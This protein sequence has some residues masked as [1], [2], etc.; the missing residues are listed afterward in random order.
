MS[1][2]LL[3]ASGAQTAACA[4]QIVGGVVLAP[5]LSGT[6]QHFKARLQGRCG[7][8]PLQP[9]RELR[10]LWSRSAVTVEGTT[11]VHR[12]APSVV[13][14]GLLTAVLLVP[15]ADTGADLP[16]GHDVLTLMGLLALARFALAAASWDTSNG[17]AL[18]GACRDLM[19]SVH[20]EGTLILA[21]AVAV[22]AAGTTDL[23][24]MIAATAGGEVWSGP[25][26]IFGGVAFALVLVA[27]IGRQPVDNPDTHLELTMI[28]EGPLLEYSGR[29]LAYLHWAAHARHWVMFLLAAQ[30]FLPHPSGTWAQL[31]TL[32]LA[33]LL[34]CVVLAL[35]ESL[36]SKMRVM[37][38]P[39]FLLIGSLAALLG[40]LSETVGIA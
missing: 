23:R 33:M 8:T 35:V 3:G 7:P 36:L 34:L 16:V 29:D 5:L 19:V 24:G 17:F 30:I 26:L 4:V 27:E 1:D 40:I 14:A 11:V 22:L 2:P 31:A 28:H 32:P 9:Y 15:C 38:S 37:S 6:I 18:I 13:A 20:A 25:L 10:R 12:A 21:T 39:R